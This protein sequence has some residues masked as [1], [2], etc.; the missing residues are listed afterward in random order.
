[1]NSANPV[2]Y[3]KISAS[4]PHLPHL[5]VA[6]AALAMIGE[7]KR[8]ASGDVEGFQY[9]VLNEPKISR[10]LGTRRAF[11]EAA[12]PLL[13]DHAKV[14][15]NVGNVVKL[16]AEADAELKKSVTPEGVC[17]SLN[18]FAYLNYGKKAPGKK[19]TTALSVINRVME[20]MEESGVSIRPIRADGVTPWLYVG[21]LASGGPSRLYTVACTESAKE[22]AEKLVKGMESLGMAFALNEDD[23]GIIHP[24]LSPGQQLHITFPFSIQDFDE[25]EIALEAEAVTKALLGALGV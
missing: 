11:L 19:T 20:G 2:V 13:F 23:G 10:D 21:I 1:M 9:W 16:F 15:R 25:K 18:P 7:E 8:L 4:F 22:V 3:E 14:S 24:I 17:I 12:C 6:V 5:R